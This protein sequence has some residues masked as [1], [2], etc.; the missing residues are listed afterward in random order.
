MASVLKRKERPFVHHIQVPNE[1]LTE[2]KKQLTFVNN[3]FDDS[4]FFAFTNWLSGLLI[5]LPL[6]LHSHS[7][8]QGA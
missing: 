8:G 5:S 3:I 4:F 1:S 7:S 6:Q 2:M